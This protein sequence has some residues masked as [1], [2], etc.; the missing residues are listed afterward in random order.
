MSN[1]PKI[2][3]RDKNTKAPVVIRGRSFELDI[4]CILNSIA[5]SV[6]SSLFVIA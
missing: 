3:C 5:R 2:G 4:V 1:Q 6:M